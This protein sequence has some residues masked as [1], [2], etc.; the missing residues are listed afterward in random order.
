MG[1]LMPALFTPLDDTVDLN[2]VDLSAF[3]LAEATDAL[4]GDDTVT[5]SETQ[6]IGRRFNGNAGDDAIT[7]SS[8]NDQINGGA[9]ADTLEGGAGND[10]FFDDD[11]AASG[12]TYT[13]VSGIDQVF[14]SGG[15]VFDFSA[16]GADSVSG[17]IEWVQFTDASNVTGTAGVNRLGGSSDGD[18]FDGLAGNDWIQGRD[19]ND[20][21][22]GGTGADRL[23]GGAGNDR[24]FD[25]DGA[26]SGDRYDGGSGADQ[27]FYS[28][29]SGFLFDFSAA[30]AD[31]IADDITWVQ[32]TSGANVTGT[33]GVNRFGG[34]TSDDTL[35]GLGGNDWLQGK[36]GNDTLNGDGG[37]DRLEGGD[38][39]D[40][41]FGGE[42]NDR[43]TGGAGTDFMEGGAGSDVFVISIN[44]NDTVVD[45]SITEDTLDLSAFGFADVDAA[46]AT[47]T[48]I[49][50]GVSFNLP[51]ATA[52]VIDNVTLADLDDTNLIV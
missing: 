11:G 10:L 30:G 37:N 21:I 27:V 29:A 6:N 47:G 12:D 4:A 14:Y 18:T 17:D 43:L 13:D 33:D 3:T 25:D 22:N 15:G 19:G 20:I 31:I 35:N 46:K 24:F 5:L 52:F 8:N 44:G 26:A 41:L 39:N 1:L 49:G 23:D 2:G 7:G 50:T 28:G 34:S 48:E 38:G 51:S 40:F 42:G 36:N 16:A 45:F 9:D 32:F